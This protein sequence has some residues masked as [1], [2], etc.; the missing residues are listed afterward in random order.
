MVVLAGGS[1]ARA[2][3][4]DSNKVYADV[5]GRPL[6]WY[7]LRAAALFHETTR[8]LVVTRPQDEQLASALADEF[9]NRPR[10]VHGG[11]T[12][13]ASERQGIEAAL[14]EVGGDAFIGIHDGARPFLTIDLWQACVRAAAAH[15]G[16]VPTLNAGPLYRL[17]SGALSPLQHGVRR[18]QTP[19][20]FRGGELLRAFRRST[21]VPPDTAETVMRHGDLQI[22]AVPGDRRNIKVTYP[23]DLDRA[24]QLAESWREGRWLI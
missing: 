17:K 15:G 16:A 14:E 2:G 11:P 24:C 5:N 22:A 21:G 9:P 6:L 13:Y 1:G 20:V 19:Q 4:S 10:L 23:G 8:I 3:S 12:R 7:P 18:A